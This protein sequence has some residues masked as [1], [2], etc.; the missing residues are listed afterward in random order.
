[1]S[2]RP[3]SLGFSEVVYVNMTVFPNNLI[4]RFLTEAY[5]SVES[6]PSFLQYRYAV[7]TSIVGQVDQN[8]Y[9]SI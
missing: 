8:T 7:R 4:S 1:M 9:V 5:R 2:V 6:S 3:G